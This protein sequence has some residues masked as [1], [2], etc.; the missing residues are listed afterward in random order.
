M[1]TF[2]RR[3]VNLPGCVKQPT[4]FFHDGDLDGTLSQWLFL[5]PL[6]GGIGSI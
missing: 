1:F 2:R 6:K 5:V 4:T 3:E